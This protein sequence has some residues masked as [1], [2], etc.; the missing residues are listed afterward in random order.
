MKPESRRSSSPLTIA[1]DTQH[2]GFAQNGSLGGAL[3]VRRREMMTGDDRCAA[4][5][6]FQFR[7][8]PIDAWV[9]AMTTID[10]QV[11]QNVIG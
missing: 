5:T 1:P 9:L 2:P 7:A 10:T 11:S 3:E 4:A 6:D 8:E